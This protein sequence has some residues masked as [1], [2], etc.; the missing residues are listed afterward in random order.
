MIMTA[1]TRLAVRT[2]SA[3]EK[4][5]LREPGCGIQAGRAAAH[6]E[7]FGLGNLRNVLGR[8]AGSQTGSN[9]S[10]CREK[11]GVFKELSSVHNYVLV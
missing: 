8:G 2:P 4:S 10:C 6:N 9:R 3:T 7:Q 1:P 11:S 5:S